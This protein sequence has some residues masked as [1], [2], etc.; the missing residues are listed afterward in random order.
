[1]GPHVQPWSREPRRSALLHCRHHHRHPQVDDS[2]RTDEAVHRPIH[3]QRGISG[4]KRPCQ[5]VASLKRETVAK[6][7][8][9][10]NPR[11]APLTPLAAAPVAV[12]R[13][14]RAIVVLRGHKVLLDSDLATLYEVPT[15]VLLQAV[16]R[17][18]ERFPQDFMFRLNADEFQLL[19]SQFVTSNTVGRGGRRYA[20]YAF[21]EQGVAMLSSVLS[22][23]RAV[24]VNIE[25]MRAFVRLRL[26]LASNK[27]L[28]RRLD[29]L[30]AKTDAKFQAVFEAIRQ[31]MATPEPKKRPFGFVTRNLKQ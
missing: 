2:S 6:P 20:P 12:E 18:L 3:P 11:P 19:R 21:S 5:R 7:R 4:R 29:Q 31:L 9:I 27:E 16:K 14:E 23:P 22:S 1:L 25:V 13:I 26:I 28:T 17:N 10:A 15:K 30:E 24:A 8:R